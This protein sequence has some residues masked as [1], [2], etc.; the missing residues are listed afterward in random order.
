MDRRWPEFLRARQELLHSIR[1][2]LKLQTLQYELIHTTAQHV[3]L[4]QVQ[5]I[6][7]RH[8]FLALLLR[9]RQRRPPNQD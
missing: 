5:E 8:L 2:S 3:R 7:P 1:A 9:A 4:P 6:D